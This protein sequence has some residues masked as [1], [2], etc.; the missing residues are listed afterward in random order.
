MGASLDSHSAPELTEVTEKRSFSCGADASSGE[1]YCRQDHPV[2]PAGAQRPRNDSHSR[3]PPAELRTV[4]LCVS[5]TAV[6]M[7]CFGFNPMK[8]LVMSGLVQGFS[9]PPLMLLI[10]VMTNSRRL[11][12][13]RVNGRAINALAAVT[14]L[15]ISAASVTLLVRLVS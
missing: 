12:H 4:R 7:N 14:L 9:T 8:M 10:V 1:R 13:D 11:M 6:L 2:R 15:A 5:V 3:A